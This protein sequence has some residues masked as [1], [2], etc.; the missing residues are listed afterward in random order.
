MQK[1]SDYKYRFSIVC[2]VYNVEDYVGE[3]I[4][5]FIDQDIGFR[6]HVQVILVDDGSTD[7]SADICAKYAAEYPKNIKL[8]RKENG[9]V[10]TARNIGLDLIE[11]KYYN[12]CDPDDLLTSNTLSSVWRFFEEHEMETDIVTIPMEF[13]EAYGGAPY[14]NS[15][16]NRGTRLIDLAR[17]PYAPLFSSS[18]SFIHH[19][20]KDLYRFDTRLRFSEDAKYVNTILL[21]KLTLGVVADCKY[22]YRRRL[23]NTSA[24]NSSQND[25]RWYLDTPRYFFLETLEYAKR[26][27]GGKPPK[28]LQHTMLSDMKWRLLQKKQDNKYL[29]S[30]DEEKFSEYMSLITS[31]LKEIEPDVIMSN[32]FYDDML[33]FHVINNIQHRYM[34][35]SHRDGIEYFVYRGQRFF[36]LS[37]LCTIELCFFEPKND[38]T[39]E[40]YLSAVSLPKIGER[41][42][43]LDINGEILQLEP[44]PKRDEYFILGTLSH[45]R[46]YYRVT[47]P[48]GKKPLYFSV[49][50]E[51]HVNGKYLTVATKTFSRFFPLCTVKSS[52]FSFGSHVLKQASKDVFV[53][54][55]MMKPK[56]ML[57][58]L[59]YDRDLLKVKNPKGWKI[60]LHRWYYF[61]TKTFSRKQR[62]LLMDRINKAD[63]NAE[64]FFAYTKEKGRSRLRGIKTSFAISRGADF[65]R[66]SKEHDNIIEYN[67]R[68]F[69]TEYMISDALISSHADDFILRPMGWKQVY[70]KDITCRKKFIFLQHGVTQNDISGYL[71]KFSKNIT[72]F[73]AVSPI[74]CENLASDSYCYRNENIWLTGFARFDRLYDDNKRLITIMPTWRSYLAGSMN[75]ETGVW[76]LVP[77]F[78][79]SAFY[80]FYNSLL[81]DERLLRAAREH[82]YRICFMAHPIF[83]PNINRFEKNE[84]VTFFD[85]NTSYR[86]IY[87]KSALVLTD[88]SSAVFDFAYLRKPVVYAQFDREEL[89]TRGNTYDLNTE[90]YDEHALGEICSD[91]ESTVDTL[92]RYIESDCALADKYRA[93]MD[94]F[95][96]Y[97]DRN[98]CAR[99][100]E[101]MESL[102]LCKIRKS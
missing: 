45:T 85:I 94:T 53:V 74:E 14:H 27:Y 64:A 55:R 96:A 97:S 73:V 3:T 83:A 75:H 36:D 86:D 34:T 16:F 51:S 41:H 46:C 65:D 17:E 26:V 7:S 78:E 76:S 32:P 47:F 8:V 59:R 79:G 19:R 40:L 48:V 89:A 56:R 82:G 4:Q 23:M 70:N 30:G 29:R 66:L 58:E 42:F 98:N 61:L 24:I 72:G 39:V 18:S 63:D 57:M 33:K 91:L 25:D 31:V 28:F 68:R 35:V 102:G 100:A 6:E 92:I 11:G 15:K 101:H 22:M 67:T 21:G 90:F 84:D 80:K 71:N 1:N 5:S 43:V 37:Q 20:I 77:D 50:L 93:R 2:A 49:K 87:A 88:Y 12:F 38:G 44:L 81:N 60:V 62:W 52:Y 10:S 13:F 95:F 99:I 54:K 9:G 69:F